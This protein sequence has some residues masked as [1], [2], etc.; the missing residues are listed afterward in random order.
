MSETLKDLLEYLQNKI[1][2]GEHKIFFNDLGWEVKTID[3][4]NAINEQQEEIERLNYSLEQANKEIKNLEKHRDI[5]IKEYDDKL[6]KYDA[7]IREA[8]DYVEHISNVDIDW[9]EQDRIINILR[10]CDNE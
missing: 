6:K 2:S 7:I 5:L 1:D 10:K 4:I 3:C 8:I 9:H